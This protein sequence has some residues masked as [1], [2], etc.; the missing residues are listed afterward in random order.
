MNRNIIFLGIAAGLLGIGFIF[1]QNE[2]LSPLKEAQSLKREADLYQEQSTEDSLRKAVERYALVVA[3]FPA[4]AQARESLFMLAQSYEKLGLDDIAYSKYLVLAKQDI[5]PSLKDKLDFRLG[6]LKILRNRPEEG[7][8]GLLSLLGRT[9][10]AVLRSEIYL[11]LGDLYG[12][13]GDWKKSREYYLQALREDPDNATALKKID[14]KKDKVATAETTEVTETLPGN[15]SELLAKGIS[16]FNQNRFDEAFVQFEKIDELFFGT[17]DAEEALYYLGNGYMAKSDYVKAIQSFNRVIGNKNPTRDQGAYLKKGEAYFH[18]GQYRNA[19]KIFAYLI[20]KYPKGP[21]AQIALDWE[22]ETRK[23][24]A[25][26]PSTGIDGEIIEPILE[27]DKTSKKEIAEP[28]LTKEP[29]EQKT[30]SD[31]F[32]L[33]EE[34]NNLLS[35]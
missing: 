30:E 23:R 6:K 27:G 11:E 8:N 25:G 19:A 18:R 28:V 26:S 20:D 1:L 34:E 3:R 21:Y 2:M 24:L 32:L 17:A 14:G 33:T 12:K 22:E 13:N 5:P 7:V 29:A 15:S 35:P 9:K 31:D 4:T 16:L 10:D